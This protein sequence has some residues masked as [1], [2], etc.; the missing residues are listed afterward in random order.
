MT[1]ATLDDFA[2]PQVT[3]LLTLCAGAINAN[4]ATTS[5]STRPIVAKTYGWP[6]RPER[7]TQSETPL[8]CI[9][10][11]RQETVPVT[12]KHREQRVTFEFF[13]TMGPAPAD[14]VDARWRLPPLVW[15]ELTR[16]IGKGHD[17]AVSSDG[18]ILH[19]A[20]IMRPDELRRV[21]DYEQPR[22][23]GDVWPGF[24]GT[25]VISHRDEIDVSAL[26]DL[27]QLDAQYRLTNRAG[28]DQLQDESPTPAVGSET[29]GKQPLVRELL[30][31]P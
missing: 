22:G 23:D 5:P 12:I 7:I 21:V 17:P 30:E 27:L 31:T 24:V 3:A 18:L 10:R 26:Q 28:S 2:D 29:Q 4:L 14:R 9:Y 1:V 8:L 15:K 6:V 25:M 20:G 19:A 11:R 13:Y 16:V